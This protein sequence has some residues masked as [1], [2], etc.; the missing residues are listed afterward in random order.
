MSDSCR[1][2]CADIKSFSH[3]QKSGATCTVRSVF[4]SACCG[5]M[6]PRGGRGQACGL[7][8]TSLPP[9]TLLRVLWAVRIS[10]QARMPQWPKA[11]S[12][13]HEPTAP[14]GHVHMHGHGAFGRR[15]NAS[16]PGE[17]RMPRRPRMPA[18]GCL[19]ATW[20]PIREARSRARAGAGGPRGLGKSSA[21][22]PCAPAL[23][24]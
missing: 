15:A 9:R 6:Y 11:A 10:P 3:K 16:A 4:L 13:P 14:T 19:I 8:G 1:G 2:S 22:A 5:G 23:E 20:H 7:S 21:G 17:L 24:S 18:F 12:G